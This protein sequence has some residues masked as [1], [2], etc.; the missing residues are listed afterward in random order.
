[1]SE[2]ISEL[3]AI[4]DSGIFSN[5]GPTNTRLELEM[6]RRLFGGE[7][8]CLT[9]NNATTGL[10]LAIKAAAQRRPGAS[11][12]LIPSFTFAAT[13]HAAIWAGLTPLLY[14]IDPASWAPSAAAENALIE[15]YGDKIAVIVPYATFGNCI[16]LTRYEAL[17]AQLGIGVVVDA[18]ASLGS[19]DSAG[20]GFGTGSRLPIVYSM[21]VTKTFATAEAGMIYSADADLIGQLRIMGNYGFGQPRSSTMPGLNSKLSEIGALLAL[22]K[23]EGFEEVVRRRAMIASVYRAELQSCTFQ[24]L[25][26]VRHAFQF[27]PMLLPVEHTPRRAKILSRLSLEG[28]GCGSYFSPHLAEQPYFERVSVMAPLPATQA[29]ADRIISLPMSDT[30]TRDEVGLVCTMLRTMLQ[31]AA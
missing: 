2:F 7:G 12:A 13:A 8:S 19:L 17:S 29:V 21:H 28:V 5:Y 27:M 14:D 15:Q 4:E 24:D 16:D 11:Y 18:A 22:K 3:Q 25:H 10:M 26:G 9:V 20:R 31:E 6:I 1:L 30:I 23:L